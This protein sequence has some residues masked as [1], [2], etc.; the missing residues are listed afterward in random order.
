MLLVLGADGEGCDLVSSGDWAA[1]D[2]GE[3]V[4][5][6]GVEDIDSVSL[7]EMPTEKRFLLGVP[8]EPAGD[9][10]GDSSWTTRGESCV[11]EGRES[12]M[13]RGERAL[14]GKTGACS[15]SPTDTTDAYLVAASEGTEEASLL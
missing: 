4:F 6:I 7:A 15:N 1:E 5:S 8:G 9:F 2:E 10:L 3:E 11:G 14:E 13:V 12:A